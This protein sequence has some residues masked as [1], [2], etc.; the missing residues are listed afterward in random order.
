MSKTATGLAC[1]DCN[2]AELGCDPD[3]CADLA[4]ELARTSTRA[5]HGEVLT[6]KYWNCG[7][8]AIAIVAVAGAVGDWAAYIGATDNTS[9]E[10]A[11]VAAAAED[12]CK[13]YS[14]EAAALFPHLNAAMY[15]R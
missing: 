14:H 8:H 11:A 15:R 5:A 4:R 1:R 7:G 9:S 2:R 12:G 3:A 13:L 6:H 10:E